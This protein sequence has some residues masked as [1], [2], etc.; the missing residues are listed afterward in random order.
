MSASAA[1]IAV[2][3]PACGDA[4]SMAWS[5]EP[6]GASP[7]SCSAAH[8]ALRRSP[9]SDSSR[10]AARSSARIASVP[11]AIFRASTWRGGGAR[12]V[13]QGCAATARAPPVDALTEL[14]R[15]AALLK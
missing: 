13:A 2:A 10:T 4:I 15:D 7:T 6:A 11:G 8:F 14:G 9:R 3:S 12:Q 5:S 1:S